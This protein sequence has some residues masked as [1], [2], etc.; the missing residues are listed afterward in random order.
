MKKMMISIFAIIATLSATTLRA[1]G[2]IAPA[3]NDGT[4]V[5]QASSTGANSSK[6]RMWQNIAIASGAVAIAITALILVAENQG[7][8]HHHHHHHGQAH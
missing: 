1:D 8:H 3:T 2:S 4:A 7:G 6:S 5:G